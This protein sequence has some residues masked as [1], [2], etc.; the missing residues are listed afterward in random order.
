VART[1]RVSPALESARTV[2]RGR[3]GRSDSDSLFGRPQGS[4]IAEWR[5]ADHDAL[6]LRR[7][8]YAR[9]RQSTAR[10]Q[11]SSR[12]SEGRGRAH[13]RHGQRAGELDVHALIPSTLSSGARFKS[14]RTPTARAARVRHQVQTA[15]AVAATTDFVKATNHFVAS[16]GGLVSLP[17]AARATFTVNARQTVV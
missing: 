4:R 10:Q 2:A 17:S 9:G 11:A 14:S 12:N 6:A 13:S 8:A 5:R 1:R 7:D 16:L 15:L 3:R